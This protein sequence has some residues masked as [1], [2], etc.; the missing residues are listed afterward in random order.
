MIFIKINNELRDLILKKIM[1][2][3]LKFVC[4]QKI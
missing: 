4:K 3:K 2:K 1:I